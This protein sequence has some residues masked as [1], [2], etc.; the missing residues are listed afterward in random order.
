MHSGQ[1]AAHI[2]EVRRKGNTQTVAWLVLCLVCF[3]LLLI[4]AHR[5]AERARLDALK[6]DG[7]PR[8]QLYAAGLESALDKYEYLPQV[9]ALNPRVTE[10]LNDPT[11]RDKVAAVNSYLETVTKQAGALAV[12]LIDAEG[13][14]LAASNWQQERTFVGQD[15]AFR[16]Y[17]K[18]A[19]AGDTGRFYGVGTTSREAGYYL[20]APVWVGGRVAGVM[21]AKVKLEWLEPAWQVQHEKIIVADANN[22]VFLS[23]R[24][25]WKYK[26]FAWL[27]PLVQIE[28]DRTQQYS[29]V[30]VAPLDVV[31]R[32]EPD[33]GRVLSIPRN[34]GAVDAIDWEGAGKPQGTPGE[35]R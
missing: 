10:L 21:V 23:S 14:T 11:N 3:V 1:T 7:E 2:S 6:T 17:F 8:L 9:T 20:S 29:A 25:E 32:D 30:E 12:Y 26:A 34:T 33:V 19:M 35:R 27:S 16:P 5:V 31:A 4:L 22:I 28:L 24:P 18:S 13:L 15:Y